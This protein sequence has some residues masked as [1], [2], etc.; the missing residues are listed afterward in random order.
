MF[1]NPSLTFYFKMLNSPKTGIG[2]LSLEPLIKT[3]RNIF[4]LVF[5]Q[6]FSIIFGTNVY[7]HIYVCVHVV[8]YLQVRGL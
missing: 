2:A 6:V 7:V 3:M 4:V 8:I 1:L 5:K